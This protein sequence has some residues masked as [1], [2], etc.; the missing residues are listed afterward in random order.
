MSLSKIAMK[1]I[2]NG[3]KRGERREREGGG[4]GDKEGRG[5]GSGGLSISLKTG[6]IC[7]PADRPHSES[8]ELEMWM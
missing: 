7:M 4:K 5:R 3:R 6:F 8:R 2:E 1:K